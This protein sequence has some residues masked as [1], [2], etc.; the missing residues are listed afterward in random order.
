M[1]AAIDLAR[2]LG[3]YAIKSGWIFYTIAGL[4]LAYLL[5]TMF[6]RRKG[7]RPGAT[8]REPEL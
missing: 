6:R 3:R 8:V 7:E 4:F 5:Y 1:I 2:I